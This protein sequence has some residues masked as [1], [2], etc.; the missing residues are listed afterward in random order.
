MRDQGSRM[1]LTLLTFYCRNVDCL[2]CIPTFALLQVEHVGGAH[3]TQ[4][5]ER[6]EA[7]ALCA[8]VS[9]QTDQVNF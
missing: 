3:L 8:G 1:F 2:W 7:R 9:W 4:P 6:L 5:W